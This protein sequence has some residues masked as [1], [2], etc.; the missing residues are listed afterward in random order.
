M[1][2]QLGHGYSRRKGPH[3]SVYM[4]LGWSTLGNFVQMS[5]AHDASATVGPTEGQR[6][7]IT[8]RWT[9]SGHST[10]K[11]HG[12]TSFDAL[13]FGWLFVSCLVM[14][15]QAGLWR[16][17]QVTQQLVSDCHLVT[18]ACPY[19]HRFHNFYLSANLAQVKAGLLCETQFT[20]MPGGATCGSGRL[21]ISSGRARGFII[22]KIAML[23]IELQVYR[24]R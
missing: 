8:C 17:H 12:S 11:W 4:E 5:Q 19:S 22:E 15:M 16:G 7:V 20:T 23:L 18:T 6:R 3:I 14:M 24:C 21:P 13:C 10:R 9:R 2:S 1:K